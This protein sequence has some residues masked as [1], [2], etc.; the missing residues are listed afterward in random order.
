[1]NRCSTGW[2]LSSVL[3]AFASCRS[4][5]EP[6][7]DTAATRDAAL[8]EAAPV[9]LVDSTSFLEDEPDVVEDGKYLYTRNCAGCH[10]DNG[11]GRGPTALE[12]N[13]VARSFAEGNFAF[14]NTRE[15]ILRTISS[16]IPG[17]SVMPAFAGTLSKEQ[18][19][20]VVDYV[21]TLMPAR[22][23]EDPKIGLMSVTD[24]PVIVRGSLPAIVE[25]AK[26]QP[27][28]LL[29]GLPEGLTFEY[30]TDDVGLLGVR[31][32]DFVD[33]RDW[34]D[35]G[36]ST[37]EPLGRV[38]W[39]MAGG[40]PP[41]CFGVATDDSI[42]PARCKLMST[43]VQTGASGAG[44]SYDVERS[45]GPRLSVTESVRAGH[46]SLGAGFERTFTMTN[47]TATAW[48]ALDVAGRGAHSTWKIPP[49]DHQPEAGPSTGLLPQ[50]GWLALEKEGAGC[51]Y[52]HVRAPKGTLMVPADGIVRILIEVPERRPVEISV[53]VIV[54][55][56]FTPEGLATVKKEIQ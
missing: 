18:C 33:R 8:P 22:P 50:D 26:P 32:G 51:D 28:G 39:A 2:L 12:L 43:W 49:L 56:K 4:E 15:S 5:P 23:A 7:R 47:S 45:G 11:D 48:W 38:I 31:H 54:A 53:S 9:T 42:V 35:R 29:I 36:G 41:P 1:M 6:E 20:L 52:V 16:G 30:R 46:S 25:G 27:R 44:L 3:V 55:E 17:R 14:G 37:L 21:I 19:E 13:V 40:D 34:G 10:N 24:R